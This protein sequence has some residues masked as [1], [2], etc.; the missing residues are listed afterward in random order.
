MQQQQH[1]LQVVEYDLEEEHVSKA[2][3]YPGKRTAW[4]AVAVDVA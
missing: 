4:E 1:M 3:A 2:I